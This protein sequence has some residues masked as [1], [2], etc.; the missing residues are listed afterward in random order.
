[1]LLFYHLIVLD[2][3]GGELFIPV[4]K[5]MA[6]G[7]RLL[8]KKSEIPKLLAHLQ[9]SATM[10]D[11]WKQRAK[12]NAKLFA[13][14]SPFDLAEIVASLSELSYTRSLTVGESG[15]LGKARRLLTCEIS[16]V[17]GET[18]IAAE[19]QLDQALNATTRIGRPISSPRGEFEKN[20]GARRQLQLVR[21]TT[22]THP[23]S[24]SICS[25]KGQT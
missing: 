16:E 5:A 1:M 20:R 2:E 6:I 23:G 19:E 24:K 22:P 18:K 9:K 11:N 14:G 12:D 4:E 8:M 17:M 13:S 15:T 25:S 7:V 3:S 10:A 21:S